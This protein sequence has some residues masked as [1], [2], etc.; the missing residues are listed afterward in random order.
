MQRR[1]EW[2]NR[3]TLPLP[4]SLASLKS[5]SA[6]SLFLDFDGT[7]IEIAAGPDVIEVP[8][9]IAGRLKA[10]AD[11]IGGRLA[12]VSGR[13]LGNLEQHLGKLEIARAGSHGAEQIGA[14]G[15]PLGA[16]IKPIPANDIAQLRQLA[17]QHGALFES[18]RHGAALH[19]RA[20]PA[21]GPAIQDAAAIIAK[22]SGL[23][24]KCGKCVIEL[25]R[26][27]ANKGSAIATFM[28]TPIFAGS[29]P[30]FIGDDVTDEDGFT[31]V[32]KYGGLAIAVG[33]R[34]SHTANFKLNGV[35]DVHAWLNL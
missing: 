29:T 15:A 17:S 6:V 32:Q 24:M 20:V 7:L 2:M 19:F 22:Q 33:E 34:Q 18:K 16:K 27:G 13:D 8:D 31:A 35:Q 1:G 21:S 25:V 9:N 4:P 23:T 30:I 12:L 5:A 14:D 3:S 11:K 26:P 28:N 10:V